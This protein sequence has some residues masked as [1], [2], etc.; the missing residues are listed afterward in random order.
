MIHYEDFKDSRR[1]TILVIT[2][3]FG[4]NC[5]QHEHDLNAPES[6]YLAAVFTYQKK[7]CFMSVNR[8]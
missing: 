3:D 5:A 8:Y 2:N 1:R 6:L 7:T 4:C